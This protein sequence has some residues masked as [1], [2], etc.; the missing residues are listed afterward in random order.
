MLFTVKHSR[1]AVL[2]WKPDLANLTVPANW[3]VYLLCFAG[4]VKS[5][6]DLRGWYSSVKGGDEKKEKRSTAQ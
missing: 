5:R 4:L 1:I 2:Y 3:Q 6:N